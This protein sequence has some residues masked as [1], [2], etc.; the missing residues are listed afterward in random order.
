MTLPDQKPGRSEQTVC[1]PRDFLDAVE[2]RFGRIQWDCAAT[3]DNGVTHNMLSYFG[4]DHVNPDNR[5][6]LTALWTSDCLHWCNP[7]FS[8]IGPW[9]EKAASSGA[10]V[11][12]L[13]PASVGSEWFAAH[14]HR[15]AYVLAL[16]PRLTFNG[17]TDPYPKDLMLLVYGAGLY[18]FDCW[19]WK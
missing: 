15:K 6:G 13:L 12:M 14:V 19:R 5:D 3:R 9:V 11:L 4:P 18:G 17:H 8:K 16:S 2:N 10:N 1:T 7:P